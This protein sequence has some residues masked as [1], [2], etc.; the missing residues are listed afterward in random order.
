MVGKEQEQPIAV[1]RY[2]N[3]HK[4]RYHSYVYK[5]LQTLSSRLALYCINLSVI[6]KVFNLN[7]QDVSNRWLSSPRQI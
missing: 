4:G 2:S 6:R 1:T 5:I 3:A 7:L